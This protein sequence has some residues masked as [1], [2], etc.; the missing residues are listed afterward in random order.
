MKTRKLISLVLAAVICLGMFAGC[1]PASTDPT[2]N[3]A[4]S[5]EDASKKDYNGK[6]FMVAWWGGDARHNYTMEALEVFDKQFTNLKTSVVY[7]GWSDYFNTIIDVNMAGGNPPDV[8]QVT[9]DKIPTYAAAGKLLKLDS[10]IESGAIDTTNVADSS[11]QMG[12]YN[13]AIYA[14]PT[15]ISTSVYAYSNTDAIQ[16]GITLSR[17]PTLDEVVAAAKKMYEHNGKKIYMEFADYIRMRGA[18]Y[19]NADGTAVGFSA[20]ILADW[21]AFEKQGISEGWFLGPKDGTDSASDALVKGK[22]WLLPVAANQIISQETNSKLDI[23]WIAVPT[24]ENK[25][26]SFTQPN[27]LWVV[28]ASC[29]NP[30]LAI[31][32]LNFFVNSKDYFDL[33]GIDRG[34]PISSVINDYVTPTLDDSGKLQATIIAELTEA[35]A[36][37]AMPAS[38]ANDSKAKQELTDYMQLNK[39]G[40]IADADMLATAQEAI[41]AMNS[42]LK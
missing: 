40:N 17:T 3:L 21:W 8:F 37:G 33:G 28:S 30:E 27:T 4:P 26:A 24:A 5:L 9:F 2:N 11:V 23:E 25:S 14:V 16:A 42:V 12:A 39:Y 34:I 20:Q 19:Y 6:E 7:S 1:A 13:G 15:G 22:V 32:L 31:A 29:E 41:D 38:S 18:S 35:G 10:Y 36:F